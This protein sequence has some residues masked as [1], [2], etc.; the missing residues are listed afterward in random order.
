MRK[1]DLDQTK[2][3]W[4]DDNFITQKLEEAFGYSDEQLVK[5]FDEAAAQAAQQPNPKLMPPE[6][7][8]QKIMERVEREKRKERKTAR[9][10]R[11]WRPLLVAALLGGVVLGSG[12]GVSGNRELEYEIRDQNGEEIVF[13]NVNNVDKQ[14]NIEQIYEKI[15]N[16]L[17]IPTIELFYMPKGMTFIESYY[18]ENRVKLQFTYQGN[19]LYFHQVLSSLENSAVYT[20]DRQIYREVYNRYL[21]KNL[22]IYKNE[23]EGESPEFGVQFTNEKAYYYLFGIIDEEEFI[24]I[25][26]HMKYYKK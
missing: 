8:F 14:E 10:K 17:G 21:N 9:I 13:N 20:S 23:L 18:S 16:E 12:I 7:E 6:D 24:K 4:T 19:Y 2:D 3:N 5:E 25:V 1:E 26:E 11:I 15:E 22:Q